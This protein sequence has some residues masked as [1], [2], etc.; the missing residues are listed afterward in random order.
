MFAG[1]ECARALALLR[2]SSADCSADLRGL[3][4]DAM[5]TLEGWIAKF[6]AKYPVVGKVRSVGSA[7]ASAAVVVFA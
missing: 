5:A 3:D 4:E 1:R 2:V 6:R 7:E